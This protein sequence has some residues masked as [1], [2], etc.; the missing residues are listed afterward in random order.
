MTPEVVK[1]FKSMQERIN[2]LAK[3]L[4]E[5]TILLHEKNANNIAEDEISLT[6]LEIEVEKLKEGTAV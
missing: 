3:R 4:D 2:S 6:D 1:E 5:M